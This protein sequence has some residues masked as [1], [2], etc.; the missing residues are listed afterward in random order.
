MGGEYATM[1]LRKGEDTLNARWAECFLRH[2][3]AKTI[4]NTS[5]AEVMYV[6]RT[7][8]LHLLISRLQKYWGGVTTGLRDWAKV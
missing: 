2:P 5:H 7:K 4:L 1:S 3:P 8:Q 6:A